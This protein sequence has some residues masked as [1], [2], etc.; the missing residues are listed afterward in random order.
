VNLSYPT[1]PTAY[2]FYIK[3]VYSLDGRTSAD[4]GLM[5]MQTTINYFKK[6]IELEPNYSL[7]HAQLAFAYVWTAMTIEPTNPKW[8]DLAR[9]EINRSQELNPKLAKAP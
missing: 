4:G 9:E 7:A 3:G 1:N 5:Q 8:V 6:A 2:E